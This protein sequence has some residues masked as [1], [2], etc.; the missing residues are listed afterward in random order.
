MASGLPIVATKV[1]GN[2]ELI[3]NG[4]NGYLVESDNIS[5]MEG[6]LKAYLSDSDLKNKHGKA[7]RRLCETHYKLEQM[8]SKYE[9]IYTLG[10][11]H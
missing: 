5:A 4:E 10:S 1:G 6:C 11:G 9:A 8:R 2:I 3:R 7:S